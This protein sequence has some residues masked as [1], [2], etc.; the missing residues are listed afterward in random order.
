MTQDECDGEGNKSPRRHHANQD[1]STVSSTKR[2]S[3]LKRTPLRCTARK[4]PDTFAVPKL[5]TSTDSQQA[6]L[7]L[8]SGKVRSRRSHRNT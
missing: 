7:R 1:A 8:N 3:C 4:S 6:P 5:R 2:L